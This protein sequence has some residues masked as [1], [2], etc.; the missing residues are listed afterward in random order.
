MHKTKIVSIKRKR[1]E[2]LRKRAGGANVLVRGLGGIVGVLL[3]T[4]LLVVLSGVGT[5]VGVWAYYTRDLPDAEEIQVVEEEFETILFYDSTGETL[6]Y[7]MTN[8]LG[9]RIWLNI[10]DI[11]E[12]VKWATISL[13]DRDFY[14]NPGVNIEGLGRALISNLRGREIQGGS[15]LTQQL[16]KNV[17]IPEQ[18]RYERSYSRKIKEVILALAITR[19][20]DK[21]QILEWY[22][23]LNFYGHFAYGIESAAQ[24][25]FGKSVHE[26]NLAEAAMLAPIPQY[27]GLNPI[28]NWDWAKR[29]QELT[30]D[31]MVETGYLTAEQGEE[32]KRI[33]MHIREKGIV[34]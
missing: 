11:P 12:A 5:V 2:R 28:D 27:P 29:R 30:L 15:S 10:A 14:T 9:D 16:V 19:K 23:N 25:Y 34:T 8:P 17:L 26:L 1:T 33:E 7:E 31:A 20:Y 32:A 6:I 24:V 22:L 21:H 4:V 18:E 13:E 3:V